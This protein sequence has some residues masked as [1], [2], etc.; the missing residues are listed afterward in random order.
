MASCTKDVFKEMEDSIESIS[1]EL[2]AILSTRRDNLLS[3]LKEMKSKYFKTER[4]RLEH[5]RDLEKLIGQV[6]KIETKHQLKSQNDFVANA[7]K[8][9]EKFLQPTPIATQEFVHDYLDNLKDTL[10]K[11]GSIVQAPYT[12]KRDAQVTFGRKGV[13]PGYLSVPLGLSHGNNNIFV[14]DMMNHRIQVFTMDGNYELK[15]GWQQLS[16]PHGIFV[17]FQRYLLQIQNKMQS[18]YLKF[19]ARV[20]YYCLVLEKIPLIHH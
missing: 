17:V 3:Q 15:F 1:N 10:S 19:K 5:V 9:K 8:E 20:V 2:I 4:I 13:K 16:K 7:K 14:V 6:G 18:T 11:Y 12:D